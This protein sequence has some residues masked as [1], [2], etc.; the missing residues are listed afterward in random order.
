MLETQFRAVCAK[1]ALISVLSLSPHSCP[2][3]KFF[4][5]EEENRL[6]RK[7]LSSGCHCQ[8]DLSSRE[9]MTSQ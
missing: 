9:T 8:L 5:P 1:H 3:L 2:L 6:G 4:T 7:R